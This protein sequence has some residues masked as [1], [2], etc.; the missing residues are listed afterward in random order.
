MEEL[1][2]VRPDPKDLISNPKNEYLDIHGLL[3]AALKLTHN[4]GK[5]YERPA[6]LL[7]NSKHGLGKSLLT[8]TFR[9][10]LSKDLGYEVPMV[11]VDCSEDTREYHLKGTLQGVGDYTPFVLGPIPA[12]IDLANEVGCCI[13]NFEE[14]S[15]LTPGAQK[16][17]NAVTDW[18]SGVYVPQVSKFFRLTKGKV[19]VVASMNPAAYGGVYTLNQ[20]LRSR[21]REFVVPEPTVEQEVEILSTLCPGIEEG[22]LEKACQLAKESRTN[23]FDYTLSTRDLVNFISDTTKFDG[24]L[25]I[26]LTCIASK[27]EGSDRDTIEE[28]IWGI[29]A[30]RVA[31]DQGGARA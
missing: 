10:K 2:I 12:A 20:D 8:A 14:I 24:D 5:L 19:I 28:R 18:R 3:D 11:V 17:L 26:P 31:A 1:K 23:V 27:F 22:T 9:K 4:D 6:N 7:F 21:F 30:V 29:F 13:L 25:R 16:V 15:A